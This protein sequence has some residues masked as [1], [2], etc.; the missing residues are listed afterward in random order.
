MVVARH[1]WLAS[2][3]AQNAPQVKACWQL[4]VWYFAQIAVEVAAVACGSIEDVG[5]DNLLEACFGKMA[6]LASNSQRTGSGAG[7]RAFDPSGPLGH[8]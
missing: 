2:E 8:G 7:K 5:L 1:V 4:N 6:A 3:V